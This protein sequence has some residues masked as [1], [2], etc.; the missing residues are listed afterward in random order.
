M[1]LRRVASSAVRTAAVAAEFVAACSPP[2]QTGGTSTQPAA[3]QATAGPAAASSADGGSLVF[4]STQFSPVEEQARMQNI[5]LKDAPAKVDFV[6]SDIGAFNDR[7]NS[8]QKA[9]KVS[10]SLV[11][12]LHGDM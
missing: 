9:G 11:G 12:G 5:I 7:M 10:F 6:P 4:F 3:Q 1:L 2:A 8:E